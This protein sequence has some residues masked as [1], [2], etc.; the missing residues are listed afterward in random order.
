[1]GDKDHCFI[2]QV[3][4]YFA[5]QHGGAEKVLRESAPLAKVGVSFHGQNLLYI[6]LSFKATLHICVCLHIPNH[7]TL[8]KQI[9]FRKLPMP[10]SQS[11]GGQL[12]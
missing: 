6:K 9:H 12:A 11:L 10:S 8:T 4:M 2:I 7:V 3:A 1:M 5:E